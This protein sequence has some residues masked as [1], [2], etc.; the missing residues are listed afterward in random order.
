MPTSVSCVY[1]ASTAGRSSAR[2]P[3]MASPAS[4]ALRRRVR[5]DR[6][7][8]RGRIASPR[9]LAFLTRRHL[10]LRPRASGPAGAVHLKP[11]G[12]HTLYILERKP[13]E[14]PDLHRSQ[15]LLVEPFANGRWTAREKLGGVLHGD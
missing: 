2:Q 5:G 3:P 14:P 8:H 9:R 13:G 11:D 10:S 4:P 12:G 6:E 7:D 1:C 15:A